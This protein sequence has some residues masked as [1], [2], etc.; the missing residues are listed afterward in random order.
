MILFDKS[1]NSLS[2]C[3]L[4]INDLIDLSS[5]ELI[6]LSSIINRELNDDN[7]NGNNSNDNDLSDLF[8]I[9]NIDSDLSDSDLS[10]NDL[11]DSD[12]SDSDLSNNDLSDSDLSDND[13]S[14][15]DLSDSDLS[16]NDLSD[17]D[18]SDNDLSDGYTKLLEDKYNKILNDEIDINEVIKMIDLCDIYKDGSLDKYKN[19]LSKTNNKNINIID[20][21]DNLIN[22]IEM[23]KNRGKKDIIIDNINNCSRKNSLFYD[24]I[25]KNNKK[26]NIS[27]VDFKY[28]SQEEK[29]ILSQK[30]NINQTKYSKEDIL[31]S[32]IKI[33]NMYEFIEMKENKFTK[34]Q[35][36]QNNIKN[37]QTKLRKQFMLKNSNFKILKCKYCG[38]L[39]NFDKDS[40]FKHDKICLKINKI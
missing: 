8:D 1:S 13:L 3:N 5:N 36:I 38:V 31:T 24:N 34:F 29:N 14:D 33:N 21:F 2:N 23:I 37:N 40:L 9:H 17:N 16:D 7:S 12:L 35:T 25:Y 18:L 22:D 39:I 27:N 4:N 28:L 32:S 30:K 15:S 10:D 6:D 26:V 11:S 20:I 19:I